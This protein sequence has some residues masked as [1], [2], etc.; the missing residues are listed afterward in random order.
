[1]D[2]SA[3]PLIFNSY[4]K[5]MRLNWRYGL[6]PVRPDFLHEFMKKVKKSPLIGLN[7]TI[8]YKERIILY[9]DELNEDATRIGAVN[10]IHNREGR[11]IGFNTDSLGF[12]WVLC[13]HLSFKIKKAVVL[14][15]GGAARSVIYSL[16]TEGTEEI[17]FFTRSKARLKKVRRDFAFITGLKGYLWE[18]VKIK[19]KA[20]EADLIINAT[21]VGMFPYMEETPLDIDFSI[22]KNHVAFDLIYNPLETRFLKEAKDKGMTTENGVRMF[23]YQALESLKIWWKPQVEERLFI[24]SSEEVL[25]AT[26]LERG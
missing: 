5:R 14:G 13:G 9:M 8:P 17:V 2:H 3:S 22:K 21:P 25:N 12:R 6:F 15:A 4:F 10:V 11:L 7:V 20:R 23:I 26:L 24:Q 19:E 1:M 18:K 16:H